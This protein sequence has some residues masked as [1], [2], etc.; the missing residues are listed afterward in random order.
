MDREKPRTSNN[1]MRSGSLIDEK[2]VAIGALCLDKDDWDVSQLKIKV[3]VVQ[4][5]NK[6]PK[7]KKC[8]T[9]GI[10]HTIM[11]LT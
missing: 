11:S 1:W 10:I 9:L 3:H 5:R 7:L 8:T 2:F 6:S 4:I